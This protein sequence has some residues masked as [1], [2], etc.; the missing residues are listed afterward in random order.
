MEQTVIIS[1]QYF[2][3]IKTYLVKAGLCTLLYRFFM[4]RHYFQ[5]RT[6]KR[7]LV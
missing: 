5:T 4:V 1:H 6:D 7:R 2:N 3:Y